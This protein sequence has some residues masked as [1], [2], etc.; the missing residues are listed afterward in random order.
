M[1]SFMAVSIALLLALTIV[2]RADA[3]FCTSGCQYTSRTT[4]R[5][6][7][8]RSGERWSDGCL[9]DCQCNGR[10]WSCQYKCPIVT[11]PAGCQVVDDPN[12][13]CC[14]KVKCGNTICGGESNFISPS[15][16]VPTVTVLRPG[17]GRIK[18]V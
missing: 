12:G 17:Y 9:L 5:T 11:A 4:G 15:F 7:C 14:K 3:Q 8:R 2:R 18:K 10:T 13:G 6:S 1:C 16:I